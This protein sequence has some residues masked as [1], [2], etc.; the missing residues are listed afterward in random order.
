[1]ASRQGT[2]RRATRGARTAIDERQS[3]HTPPHD[4][5]ARSSGGE[6]TRSISSRVRP[7][8]SPVRG[9][10]AVGEIEHSAV[11]EGTSPTDNSW[12]SQPCPRQLAS[13]QR[14]RYHEDLDHRPRS[15]PPARRHN[16][17]TGW[18][19]R[20]G[21]AASGGCSFGSSRRPSPCPILTAPTTGTSRPPRPSRRPHEKNPLMRCLAFG[22]KTKEPS[23][24]P[25]SP[26][27]SRRRPQADGMP[28]LGGPAYSSRSPCLQFP[29]PEQMLFPQRMNDT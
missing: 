18:L 5:D 19:P 10:I 27:R 4:A 26:F 20:L 21:R 24:L 17:G 13:T 29:L 15:G 8:R 6:I 2:C 12:S 3:S 25:G 9:K 14:P 1:M 23:C 22:R 11:E 16:P 28:R 7:C